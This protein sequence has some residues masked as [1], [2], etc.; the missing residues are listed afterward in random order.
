[1]FCSS[2]YRRIACT[3]PAH[4]SKSAALACGSPL[5]NALALTTR[6]S[7]CWIASFRVEA[8][9]VEARCEA[10][11]ARSASEWA[12]A[13][14]PSTAANT[15]ASTRATATTTHT[16][17]PRPTTDTTRSS[18]PVRALDR[19]AG[20]DCGT[21]GDSWVWVSGT[22]SHPILGSGSPWHSGE[23]SRAVRPIGRSRS[24]PLSTYRQTARGKLR[25]RV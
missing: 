21:A 3:D 4:L 10:S 11:R 6:S 17:P 8:I 18:P 1:M 22:R 12:T 15:P 5:M 19:P 16:F 2:G 25:C 7:S 13:R 24:R 20:A 14:A 23:C 9:S